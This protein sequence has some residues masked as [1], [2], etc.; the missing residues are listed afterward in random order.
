[1]DSRPSRLRLRVVQRNVVCR[2]GLMTVGHC[3]SFIMGGHSRRVAAM[4]IPPK[5]ARK[6]HE[7]FGDEGTEVMADWMNQQTDSIAEVR[8]DIA[9]LRQETRVEFAELRE[10][11]RVG[12]A[13][14]TATMDVK[15]AM[16]DAK[17]AATD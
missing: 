9:E 3:F 6:L 7:V 15:F 1:A 14:I 5:L 11:M 2:N 12:F 13:K 10:E 4:S 16:I 8:A 17:F